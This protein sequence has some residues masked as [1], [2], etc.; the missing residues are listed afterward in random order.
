LLPRPW[1][2]DGDSDDEYCG[3]FNRWYLIN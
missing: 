2:C 3:T 1:D